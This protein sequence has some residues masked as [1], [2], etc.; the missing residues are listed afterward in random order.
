M[1][2]LITVPEPVLREKVLAAL[3]AAGADEASV[4]A[5][6]HA[7]LHA[8][9]LGI[10]SHGV[11][12]TAH[13]A[14]MMKSGRINPHPNFTLRKTAAGSAMLD[15]DNGLGHAAAYA[16]M[17]YACE[18]AGEAGIGAVGVARSSHF[19]AAG[20]YALAGAEA[21]F[22]AFSTTNADSLVG[23][24]GGTEA[25]HGTNPLAIAAPVAGEKPWLMDLATSSIPFNR[26]HL[27]RT[28]GLTLPEG[29]AT[30]A[31][32]APTR[33]PHAATSL[34]PLGGTDY[35]FKGAALAGV[36]TLFSAILTGGAIDH[37]MIPMFRKDAMSTPRNVGHFCLALD[38][39]HFVGRDAYNL[40]IKRYRDALR[41]V[42]ARAGER[43][44]APG[45]REW[46]VEAA[47]LRDGIPIDVETAAFLKVG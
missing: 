24:H 14:A 44:M 27:A 20:A 37:E 35:G 28:L 5:C 10:D 26:V 2:A 21:G 42:P 15:A 31:G 16:A 25:F 11:R 36:A 13:Y 1:A 17:G 18:L 43:V 12:L 7:M 41:A 40:A 39:G 23:L 9:R 22:V 38:P 34:I 8:S 47:R 46:D 19:G 4:Q 32:G 29:V 45:D 30:D 6:A 33:D 3:T